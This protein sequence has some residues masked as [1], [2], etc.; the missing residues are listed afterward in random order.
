MAGNQKTENREQR[1]M[2]ISFLRLGR[3]KN[4]LFAG[5][6]FFLA[7]ISSLWVFELNRALEKQW[8]IRREKEVELQKLVDLSIQYPDYRDLLSRLGV[9][10]WELGNDQTAKDAFDRAK[11]LDPNNPAVTNINAAL[12]IPTP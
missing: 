2:T 5:A 8:Q 12:E 7:S 9:A 1:T 10:Q 11:Y 3:Y 6:L 4:E